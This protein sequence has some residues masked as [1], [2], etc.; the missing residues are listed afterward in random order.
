MACYVK[1]DSIE[2]D[3]VALSVFHRFSRLSRAELPDTYNIVIINTY[4]K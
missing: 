4:V 1:G 2:G 3:G